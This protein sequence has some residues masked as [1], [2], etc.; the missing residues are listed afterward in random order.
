MDYSIAFLFPNTLVSQ[1]TREI[2]AREGLKYPVYSASQ[3]NALI[4]ANKLIPKGLRLVV[5]LGLTYHYLKENLDIPI[6][7]VPFSG[8]DA[9]IAIKKALTLSDKIIHVGT[10]DLYK[11]IEKSLRLMNLDKNCIA[12]YTLNPHRS[13]K[14][15]AK[16][17]LDAGYDVIIG[18]FAAI[19]YAVSCG[20]YGI[21]F[22]IDEQILEHTI[23]N[24]MNLVHNLIEADNNSE[25]SKA[26]LQASSDGIIALD[27]NRKIFNVNPVAETIIKCS[28]AKASGRLL[29]DVLDE[30]SLVD[31]N[32]MKSLNFHGSLDVTPVILNELPVVVHKQQ[33]GSVVSIKK[34]S[35]IRD[36][37]FQIRR[38][39]VARGLVAQNTFDDITCISEVMAATKKKAFMYAQ[40]DAN[41]LIT[42]ETGVGKELF[43]HS[44]HNAS[45]RKN[46][47]FVA[48]NCASLPESLIESELFGYGKGAFTGA[49]RDGKMGLFELADKGTIFLDEISEMP[50]S[51]QSKLLRAVQS[52]EI[53]KVGGDKVVHV[54]TRIICASNKNLL[55]LINEKKFKRDLYFRISTLEITIPPLRDRPEDITCLTNALLSKI[56]L[57]Y[58]KNVHNI[59]PEVME[60][61]QNM[62]LLGN[63]RELSNIIERLVILAA[64]SDITMETFRSAF[65]DGFLEPH[66]A[67]SHSANNLKAIQR[68]TIL[69]ALEKCGGRKT[70]AAQML[71]I[72]PSTLWRKMK[73][74][75][76]NS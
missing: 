3:Q 61:I 68:E 66:A 75:N 26:I 32:K 50:V 70:M 46:Q 41:L 67:I 59:V 51:L 76:I 14:E 29:E 64:T 16:E 1:A 36:L 40:Y 18:G 74:Y 37:E 52:G 58:E 11:L 35:Q 44:I 33:V 47:P 56:S 73:A 38:D 53:I 43:A 60:K 24:S 39:L 15:Q 62:K 71:G 6:F 21:E 9:V 31:F 2:L 22:E 7:Q 55:D 20:K 57:K 19:N 4:I 49:N 54:D 63:V 34:V 13:I 42:G 27:I 23:H 69:T 45:K 30:N 28:C 48:I 5:S 72:N 17:A 25:L 8:L 10:A 65:N 12:H